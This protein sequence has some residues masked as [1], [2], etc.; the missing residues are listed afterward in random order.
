[1]SMYHTCIYIP[2][3]TFYIHVYT[4]MRIVSQSLIA[5]GHVLANISSSAVLYRVYIHVYIYSNVY[6]RTL[7]SDITRPVENCTA[8]HIGTCDTI[9]SDINL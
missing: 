8:V 9:R 7:V 6:I 3:A 2:I 5:K 1:M 4:Y